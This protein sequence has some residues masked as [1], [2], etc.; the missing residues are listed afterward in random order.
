MPY[1][2]TANILPDGL[3]DHNAEKSHVLK[4]YEIVAQFRII[5]SAHAFT[6][7]GTKK[8]IN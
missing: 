7:F 4:H 2:L 3:R 5:S 6:R 1:F 8:V